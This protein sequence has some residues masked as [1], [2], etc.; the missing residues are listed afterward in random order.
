MTSSRY[1]VSNAGATGSFIDLGLNGRGLTDPS[2]T[3]DIAYTNANGATTADRV[4]VRPGMTVDFTGAG[5]NQAGKVDIV[6]LE[7]KASE[8]M[9]TPDA[10]DPTKL[11]ISRGVGAVEMV[12]VNINALTS[13]WFADGSATVAEISAAV[14]QG[15]LLDALA[16]NAAEYSGSVSV[17]T[18]ETVTVVTLDSLGE[19]FSVARAGADMVLSG[20]QGVDTVFVEEG[21]VVDATKLGA[22]RDVVFLTGAWSDYAKTV[23]GLSVTLTRTVN[24]LDES[25]TVAASKGAGND[26]VVFTDGA[27]ASNDIRTGLKANGSNWDATADAT[28]DISTAT[29]VYTPGAVSGVGLA[30]DTGSSLTDHISKDGHVSFTVAANSD[31]TDTWEVS[32]D[33]DAANPGAATWNAAVVTYANGKAQFTVSGQTDGSGVGHTYAAGTVAVRQVSAAGAVGQVTASTAAFTVDTHAAMMTQ[34]F[35]LTGWR[36]RSYTGNAIPG[37]A[38]KA[39]N[40]NAKATTATATSTYTLETWVYINEVSASGFS[41]ELFSNGIGPSLSINNGKYYVWTGT[42]G[43]DTGVAAAANTWSHLA[44]IRKSDG[45]DLVYLNGNLIKTITGGDTTAITAFNLGSDYQGSS[46]P[47]AIFRDFA[48]FST[49]RSAAEIGQDMDGGPDFAAPGLLG[50]F[51]LSQGPGET[52]SKTAGT[53]NSLTMT[54]KGS[55]SDGVTGLA[56]AVTNAGYGGYI[57]E[58]TSLN[59]ALSGTGAEGGATITVEVAAHGTTTWSTITGTQVIN[60]DGSWRFTPT[61]GS[62]GGLNQGGA[63]DIRVWQTDAAGN[64]SAL[65]GVKTVNTWVGRP[66]VANLVDNSDTGVNNADNITS[67]TTPTITGLFTGGASAFALHISINGAAPITLTANNTDGLSYDLGQGT[68]TYTNPNA[69]NNGD[70]ISYSTTVTAG[71]SASS[72]PLTVTID[73]TATTTALSANIPATPLQDTVTLTGTAEYGSTGVLVTLTDGAGVPHTVQHPATMTNNADGTTSW[74]VTFT[75]AELA[76]LTDGPATISLYETDH[77]GNTASVADAGQVTIEAH[78]QAAVANPN[79]ADADLTRALGAD[80][81]GKI[82]AASTLIDLANVDGVSAT[83]D[84]AFT[85]P[86]AAGSN[87]ATLHYSGKLIDLGA[88]G[89]L[90]GTDDTYVALPAWIKVTDDGLVQTVAGKDV[91]NGTYHLHLTATDGGGVQA[92]RDMQVDVISGISLSNSALKGI[93]NFDVQSDIVLN[94]SG[95]VELAALGAS[96]GL[97][98]KL[99]N[100]ADPAHSIVLDLSDAADRALVTFADGGSSGTIIRINPAFD[101]NVATTYRIEVSTGAFVASDGSGKVSI[102]LDA[103][104]GLTFTTV[105]P[106]AGAAATTAKAYSFTDAGTNGWDQA[107]LADGRGWFDMTARGDPDFLTPGTTVDFANGSYVAYMGK[108]THVETAPGDDDTFTVDKNF[109]G[110]VSHFGSTDL[111]YFDDQDNAATYGRYS[112]TEIE[113]MM[114]GGSPDVEGDLG[115]MFTMGATVGGQSFFAFSVSGAVDTYAEGID[116]DGVAGI[117]TLQELAG[118]T[119]PVLVA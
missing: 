29:T 65:S 28:W 54:G 21:G 93:N 95:S 6:Y 31:S 69:Y 45:T 38:N 111:I 24:G 89:V 60:S 51:T 14:G 52:V 118:G 57:I 94:A 75:Q 96:A 81:S 46:S 12:T 16:L 61:T 15:G 63:Y 115:N 55:A 47:N 58:D 70:V 32:T 43:V 102:G 26:L 49:A 36:P 99:V 2:G 3:R 11:T 39:V 19:T 103:A 113:N 67:D 116:T 80:A 64:V 82:V 86:D 91:A 13:I 110:V 104:S 23:S 112:A 109:Y 66:A 62:G 107:T 117:N 87:N 68:W 30:N 27:M 108:I 106:S 50:Y 73:T 105:T 40:G 53:I 119:S 1:I 71:G 56:V 44:W 4:F 37:V 35:Y 74:S 18:T 78:N 114:W 101:L 33:Y 7:G 17:A 97:T 22:S 25:V 79:V 83:L 41:G 84:P 42:A 76:T 90:G 34:D 92:S 9:A 5:T 98:I 59:P 100:E 85:D 10:L 48:V 20:K 8:Y 88:D 77:A 72:S